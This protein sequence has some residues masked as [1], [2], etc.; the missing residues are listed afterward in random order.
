MG[1]GRKI[2]ALIRCLCVFFELVGG[3]RFYNSLTQL[4]RAPGADRRSFV[5]KRIIIIARSRVRSRQASVHRQ[6]Y[7]D[8]GIDPRFELSRRHLLFR[9]HDFHRDRFPLCSLPGRRACFIPLL[10]LPSEYR[11][12]NPVGR[13]PAPKS[14]PREPVILSSDEYERLLSQCDGRPML[15]LYVLALGEAGLRCESEALRLQWTDVDLEGGFLWI[16]SSSLRNHRT[17]GGKGRHVPMT[18]R[19]LA[20][21]KEHFANHRFASYAGERPP[22]VFHHPVTQGMRTSGR[23]IGSMRGSFTTA[24][25]KAKLPPG[26]HQHDL[27]HRRVT[28]WLAEGKDVVLVKEAMGHSDLRTTMGYTHLVREH[29][30]K[31]VDQPPIE[32]KSEVKAG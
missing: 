2:I 4:E 31:L 12:G 16:S 22:W 26:L 11:E 30:R 18:P 8:V 3:H 17:K 23:R 5:R 9:D 19:L 1:G 7:P 27:R 21:M 10:H 20:A 24:A 25:E 13:I 15:E 28:T 14:D 32:Q 29:L 6:D